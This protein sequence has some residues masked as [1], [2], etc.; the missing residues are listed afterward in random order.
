M[1]RRNVRTALVAIGVP[2][3]V[4]LL[5]LGLVGC[6]SGS[7][8][9]AATSEPSTTNLPSPATEKATK[10]QLP[11]GP[12]RVLTVEVLQPVFDLGRVPLNT[13]VRG[14][15]LLRNTGATAVSV[16]RLSIEVLEGC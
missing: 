2:A 15:W 12:V 11:A 7:D 13:P 8:G 10:N 14:E 16:G 3:L 5:V 4:G 6:R 9:S 1:Q